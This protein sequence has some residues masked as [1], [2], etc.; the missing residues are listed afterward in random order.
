MSR[1]ARQEDSNDLKHML[2]S[3]RQDTKKIDLKSISTDELWVLHEEIASILS[4]NMR[5]K[6]ARLE[7]LL[8]KLDG[9]ASN[10]SGQY[11]QYRRYPIVH[12]KFRNAEPPHQTWSGRGRQPHWM[13]ELLA[14]G[15]SL[16]DVRIPGR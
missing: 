4:A 6:K 16:E 2:A 8:D 1:D 13:R 3:A 15:K 9:K 10:R 12:P 11:R 7:R 14:R 5:A